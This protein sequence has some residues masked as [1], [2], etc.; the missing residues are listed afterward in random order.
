M[1]GK[2][3]SEEYYNEGLTKLNEMNWRVFDGI[4]SKPVHN[5]ITNIVN[6]FLLENI[7]TLKNT[8]EVDKFPSNVYYT[9]NT[10]LNTKKTKSVKIK[11]KKVKEE[12]KEEVKVEVDDKKRLKNICTF[13]AFVK[14]A[15]GFIIN[16][17]L[18]ETLCLPLSSIEN[19]KTLIKFVLDIKNYKSSHDN[20]LLPH[21][22]FTTIR[23]GGLV[24]NNDYGFNNL[25]QLYEDL[26]SEN[27]FVAHLITNVLRKY[28]QILSYYLAVE[29]W[30]NQKTVNLK[31]LEKCMK[32]LDTGLSFYIKNEYNT[33]TEFV[34]EPSLRDMNTFVNMLVLSVPKQ[35]TE[36]K[37]DESS[38]SDVSKEIDNDKDDPDDD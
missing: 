18:D 12:P 15:L 27:P 17:V 36:K 26:F 1:S 30:Y 20:Y 24:N 32:F 19:E 2:Q 25:R 7:N 3:T 23:Y 29:L 9:L 22:L 5:K 31:M 28:L 34:I 13:N 37:D 16:R 35:K 4:K 6:L 8:Y 38:D 21:I 33:D 10:K 11:D 14:T